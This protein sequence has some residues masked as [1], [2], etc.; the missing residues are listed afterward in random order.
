M[1]GK[2]EVLNKQVGNKVFNF[3]LFIPICKRM[4]VMKD[5]LGRIHGFMVTVFYSAIDHFSTAPVTRVCYCFM[6]WGKEADIIY[7]R[8][9]THLLCCSDS[10]ISVNITGRMI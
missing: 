3:M 5:K 1:D 4:E 10:K 6:F 2:F 8:S 9:T 7:K